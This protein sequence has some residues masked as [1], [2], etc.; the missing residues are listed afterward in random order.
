[1]KKVLVLGGVSFNMVVHVD[2]FL[3]PVAQTLH[4]VKSFYETLGNTGSG[5]ALNLNKLGF[6]VDLYGVIGE[7]EQGEK[8]R[9]SFQKEGIHFFHDVSAGGTERHLNFLKNTTGERQ[10]I[11]LNTI[12]DDI[13]TNKELVEG[14]IEKSDYVFLN[15]V[16]Y[17]KDFIPLLNKHKKEVWVDLHDYDGKND[18]HQ[19]FIDVADVIQFSSENN[20]GYRETMEE[21]LSSGKKLI[22]CTHGSKGST[23]LTAAGWVETSALPYDAIDTNGA[24]DAFFS[25]ILYG[26]TQGYEMETTAKAAS[27][28]GGITVTSK[29]LAAE[30]L[31]SDRVEAELQLK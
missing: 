13:H 30:D 2:D 7:D 5:K 28:V 24:G 8:I 10:S 1:M 3:Q 21:F 27:I 15:I 14:L 31:S 18:Y 16:S 26:I 4:S 6:D 17:C 20:P 19:P 23:I 9:S 11:F 25:G 22:I 12:P 29:E